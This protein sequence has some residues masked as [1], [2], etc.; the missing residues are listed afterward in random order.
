MFPS[1]VSFP[2]FV[3][4][5]QSSSGVL[6]GPGGQFWTPVHCQTIALRTWLTVFRGSLLG[7][8]GP[9][10]CFFVGRTIVSPRLTRSSALAAECGDR[11]VCVQHQV[12]SQSRYCRRYTRDAESISEDAARA[13]DSQWNG[14]DSAVDQCGNG[15]SEGG[16]AA[17]S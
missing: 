16:R 2:A 1:Q 8:C 14:E 12:H 4:I 3:A 13:R 7:A 9:A 11:Y 6:T 15:E 17:V 10:L 5:P